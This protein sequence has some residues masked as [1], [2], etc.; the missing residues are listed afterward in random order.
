MK[1]LRRTER[2]PRNGESGMVLV[3]VALL[4]TALFSMAAMAIDIGFLYQSQRSVQAA[5]DA[6]MLAGLP[7]LA[8]GGMSAQSNAQSKAVAMA[9]ANGY[10]DGSGGVSVTVTPSSTSLLVK[11]S[12]PQP[13]FFAGLF[14]LS[15]RSVTG[16]SVGNVTPSAPAIYAID[17]NCST[18][19]GISING[20]PTTIKGS[21]QSAG[22]LAFRTGP[23]AIVNGPATSTCPNPY[24]N[25]FGPVDTWNAGVPQGGQPASGDPFGYTIATNF[26]VAN[27]SFGTNFSNVTPLNVNTIPGIWAAGSG[28]ATGT[29]N[30]GVICSGSDILLNGTS[31]TGTI[32]MVAMGTIEAS[33]TNFNLTAA[34]NGNGLIAF[35]MSNSGS[36]NNCL[37]PTNAIQMGTSTWTLN[38][39]LYAP[40]GCISAGGGGSSFNINGSIIGYEVF[41]SL[42]GT[43][44]S[45]TG[46]GG[47]YYLQQ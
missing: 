43:I 32:T 24:Y 15:S 40:A 38:G 19:I 20:G 1:P 36:T 14:G 6:A 7:S 34:P 35:S 17:T 16:T 26:P 5:A 37:S 25:P 8:S 30:T 22:N 29:L 41:T 11:I 28:P 47:N 18:D 33:G 39:S 42:G 21:I 13:T 9:T 12:A 3:I 45:T 2:P 31:I 4:W 23:G 46:G 27:C 44:D 10:T